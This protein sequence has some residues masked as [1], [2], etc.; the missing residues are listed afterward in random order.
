MPKPE[1]NPVVVL[2]PP[3]LSLSPLSS[4]YEMILDLKW[5]TFEKQVKVS[6]E[7]YNFEQD[8][9]K[10]LNQDLLEGSESNPFIIQ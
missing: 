1:S 8:L 7:T 10:T 9:V 6:R 5:G 2:P 4:K 3:V